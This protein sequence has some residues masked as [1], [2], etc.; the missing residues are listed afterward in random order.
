MSLGTFPAET[1][2]SVS[3]CV[4]L[5]C[6]VGL[7][8]P[9][10]LLGPQLSLINCAGALAAAVSNANINAVFLMAGSSRPHG[11]GLMV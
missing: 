8:A 9:R 4:N 1:T 5:I 3:G 2:F 10:L 6:G 11:R 7:A